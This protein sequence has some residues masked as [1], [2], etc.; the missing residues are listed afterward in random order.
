M[1]FSI[2]VPVYNIEDKIY[3]CLSSIK[4]QSF[5]DFEVLVIIDGATDRSK[6]ICDEF[7][8]R[9]NR[10]KVRYKNNGGLVSARKYGAKIALG[11]YIINID[12]DD[13]VE[14][15]YLMEANSIIERYRPDI[16]AFGYKEVASKINIRK[17][18]STDGL[19]EKEKLLSIKKFVIYDRNLEGFQGGSLINTIWTKIVKR[20]KYQKCQCLIP[21]HI[22]VGEDLLLNAYLMDEISTL[23]V[24]NKAFY[25]YVVYSSSMMH[26][27]NVDNFKHYL[28]VAR[29]LN[30]IHYISENDINVYVFQAYI[31]EIRKIAKYSMDYNEF[32]E[33][34][35][36]CEE[37]SQLRE[38]A[39]RA[40]IERYNLE[41]I[42]KLII[43]H[44]SNWPFIYCICKYFC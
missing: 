23:Y 24:A 36:K 29:E 10:F 7:E 3:K 38:Y 18:A 2:I 39:R 40:K 8:Q 28:D 11:E 42:V 34:I 30:K 6:A 1:K 31:S 41:F 15:D 32:K 19:Y 20:E 37:V 35:N 17:N 33:T 43:A 13:Y 16:I 44:I 26:S 21:N 14:K 27:C 4:N 9:D 25:N 12:G 22:T 5:S